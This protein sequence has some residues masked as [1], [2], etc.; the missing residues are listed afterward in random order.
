MVYRKTNSP[1]IG[2][3]TEYPKF[4]LLLVAAVLVACMGC[5]SE[6]SPDN[7]TIILQTSP[8]INPVGI[9]TAT[10]TI[11]PPL[12]NTTPWIHLD[13]VAD[14][15]TGENFSITGT[16]N[17]KSGEILSV[18]IFPYQPSANKK[19]SYAFTEIEGNTIVRT[20]NGSTNTWS[21]SDGL[22]TLIPSYY[23]INVTAKNETLMTSVWGDFNILENRRYS[24]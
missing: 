24:S 6:H 4:A 22:T 17:L 11:C 7:Q 15:I 9:I 13:P 10:P 12:G 3:M 20:G 8:T 1:V 16:T 21:F 18:S 23:V 2:K 19:R 5:V 14:H